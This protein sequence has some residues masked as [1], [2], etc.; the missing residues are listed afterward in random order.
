MK[1]FLM[2]AG[3]AALSCATMVLAD[4]E[5]PVETGVPEFTTIGIVAVVIIGGIIYYFKSKKK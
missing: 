1:K 2:S 4:V 3:V 5:P